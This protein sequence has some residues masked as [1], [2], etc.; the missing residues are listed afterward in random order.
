M[1]DLFINN[2]QLF[3]FVFLRVSGI[4]VINPFFGSD[5]IPLP[6]KAGLSFFIALVLLPMAMKL[7]IVVP[8][9]FLTFAFAA[10]K[11]VLIGLAIG[12]FCTIIY[13]LFQTAGEFFGIPMGFGIVQVYDPTAQLEIPLIGQ[14]QALIAV[15]VF[16]TING[17]HEVLK[18]LYNSY[19]FIPVLDMSKAAPV[20]SSHLIAV[21]SHSFKIAFQIAMPMIGT[22]FLMTLVMGLLSKSAP[23]MNV[24]MLGFPVN[25]WVGMVTLMI[26]VPLL[27]VWMAK[28]FYGMFTDIN[29]MLKGLG[30]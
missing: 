2:F 9:D 22:L 7:D 19:E 25:I 28:I 14:Y 26:V 12:F 21:F 3:M 1:A 6:Y 13:S 27:C 10:G 23:Q 29:I 24:M 4:F 20:F 8:K 15:L 5:E 11:E 16:L 30:T 18:A 17:H